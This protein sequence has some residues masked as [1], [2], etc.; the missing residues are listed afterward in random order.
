MS[1][2]SES[3]A[4]YGV[5]VIAPLVAPIQAHQVLWTGFSPVLWGPNH[6]TRPQLEPIAAGGVATIGHPV[7][8]HAINGLCSIVLE[9]LFVS[10]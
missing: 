2:L 1:P 4:T 6:T 8:D 5:H 3:S 10:R 9:L 7:G